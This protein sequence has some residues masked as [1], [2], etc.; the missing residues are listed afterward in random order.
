MSAEPERRNDVTNSPQFEAKELEKLLRKGHQAHAT[1]GLLTVIGVLILGGAFLYHQPKFDYSQVDERRVRF[2]EYLDRL[3]ENQVEKDRAA[4]VTKGVS[5]VPRWPDLLYAKLRKDIFL[6]AGAG[7]LLTLIFVHIGLAKTYRNN[8]LVYRGLGR[9][10]EK[11]RRRLK[12]LEGNGDDKGE[13]SKE[14]GN[15]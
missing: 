1:I 9:E 3:V 4:Y 12:A 7:F 13:A 8:V 14:N 11:L 2:P 5:L 6:L 15:T 10:V